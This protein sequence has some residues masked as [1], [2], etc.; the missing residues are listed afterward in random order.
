VK[1]RAGR[2]VAEGP[3]LY[4]TPQ[5]YAEVR[6]LQQMH[7]ALL[8]GRRI[9]DR[10]TPRH[11][12]LPRDARQLALPRV[13]ARS[14]PARSIAAQKLTEFVDY[15]DRPMPPYFNDFRPFEYQR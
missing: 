10:E 8:E 3:L 5:Y 6:G 14:I 15:T 7:R 11:V 2:H 12:E 1:T 9:D 13:P 4:G